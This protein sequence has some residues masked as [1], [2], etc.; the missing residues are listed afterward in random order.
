MTA[1]TIA[2]DGEK[3]LED[4]S[5]TTEI[6]ASYILINYPVLPQFHEDELPSAIDPTEVTKVALR[7]RYLI[8]QTV[9]C[10]MEED[11]ITK[12]HSRVITR[13]VVKAAKEAGGKE[14]GACV[15]YCLLINKRWFKQQALLE[16]YD[17]DLHDVRAVACEVV[18]KRM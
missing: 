4:V 12:A 1:L 8:E 6:P 5:I 15:V 9:P 7:I 16:L 18:A 3:K 14:F 13:G 10:E 11:V 17:A 2:R